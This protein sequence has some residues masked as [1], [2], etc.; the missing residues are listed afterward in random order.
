[1]IQLR[2]LSTTPLPTIVDCL[3]RAFEGYFV[4][5]PTELH[6]WEQRFG[7]SG[8]DRSR[9]SGRQRVSDLCG[10]RTE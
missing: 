10:T 3:L 5:M 8:V 1:M 2:D 9:S 6:V 4:P 7:R